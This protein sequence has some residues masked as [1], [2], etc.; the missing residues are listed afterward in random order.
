V[1]SAPVLPFQSNIVISAGEFLSV[2]NAA[3]DSDKPPNTFTYQL[4]AAPN[5]ASIGPDGLITWAP[6]F[7]QVPSTNLFISIV[8]DYSPFAVNTQHLS[9]TNSFV[10]TVLPPIAPL[11]EA[12]AMADGTA[13]ITWSSAVGGIYR[14][15]T[16]EDLSDSNWT[17]V[18][19]DFIATSNSISATND[20]GLAQT[21]FYR[22]FQVQ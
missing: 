10:V 14:L 16:K 2:F 3:V 5:N 18:P 12:I 13:I 21:R 17:D 9:A 6:G 19:A 20:V 15:Q 7:G 4:L 22:V 11:I 8:T 1:N